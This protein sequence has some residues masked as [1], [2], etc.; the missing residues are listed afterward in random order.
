[1]IYAVSTPLR[2][3]LLMA[4]IFFVLDIIYTNCVRRLAMNIRNI[5]KWLCINNLSI[6]IY[7]LNDI[8]HSKFNI[9]DDESVSINDNEI[10]RVHVTKFLGVYFDDK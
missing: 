1:M 4:L 6:N 5:Y 7:F 2:H 10:T 3:T 9:L 8:I